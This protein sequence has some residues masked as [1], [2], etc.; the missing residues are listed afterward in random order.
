MTCNIII[1]YKEL[2]K[3]AEKNICGTRNGLIRKLIMKENNVKNLYFVKFY[4]LNFNVI[5]L[6]RNIIIY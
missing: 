4:N 3:A 1:S 6:F 5:I 2:K